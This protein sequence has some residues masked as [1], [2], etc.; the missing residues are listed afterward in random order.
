MTQWMG[1][2]SAG[3]A[4]IMSGALNLL[5]FVF[6]LLFFAL[7]APQILQNGEP[8]TPPL[9]GTLNDAAFIL[10]A[11]CLVPVALAL[12]SQAEAKAPIWSRITL[13]IGLLA[14]LAIAAVQA[15][16]VPR[17]ISTAQQ[18]PLLTVGLGAMGVWLM[19]VN[20]LRLRSRAPNLRLSWLGMAVGVC[21]LLMPVSYF[22]A[23]GSA[24]V[25]D[26]NTG[27]ANPLVIVGFVLGMLG[28]G[29]GFSVWAILVGRQL[30]RRSD[31]AGATGLERSQ[32]KAG[33]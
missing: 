1:P 25:S 30:L 11:L 14:F 3:W 12:H 7:E 9:F 33:A 19:V 28:L 5:G 8:S 16:Y 18:S 17:L 13:A 24:V 2:R 32:G 21:L 31:L 29:L 26:P 20:W 22:A 23:G 27:I 4:A 15:L 10:V 6:L